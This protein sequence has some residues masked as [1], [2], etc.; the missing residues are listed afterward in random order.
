M[1]AER[2]SGHIPEMQTYL[3]HLKSLGLSGVH[4][5]QKASGFSSVTHVPHEDASLD[6]HLAQHTIFFILTQRHEVWVE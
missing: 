6:C 1:W 5:L 2:I 3:R 4:H